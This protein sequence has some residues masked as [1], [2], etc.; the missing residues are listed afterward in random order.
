MATKEGS[1][2]KKF[3]DDFGKRMEKH[4]QQYDIIENKSQRRSTLDTIFLGRRVWAALEFKKEKGASE[5]PNQDYYVDKW[6]KLS[7]ARIVYPDNAEEVLDE[8]EEL[9]VSAK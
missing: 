2:K 3:K 5:Q 7:Y 4:D 9:F 6:N 8:L 1:F